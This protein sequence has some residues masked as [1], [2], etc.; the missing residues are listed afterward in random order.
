MN[1]FIPDAPVCNFTTQFALL[2]LHKHSTDVEENLDFIQK[3]YEA[4]FK[5]FSLIVVGTSL[6]SSLWVSHPCAA[7]YLCFGH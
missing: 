2:T 3:K 7:Y 4:A 1:K 6:F 5:G